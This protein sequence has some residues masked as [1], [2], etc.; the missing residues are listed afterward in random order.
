VP[1]RDY[2]YLVTVSSNVL[3]KNSA[4]AHQTLA[5]R[6]HRL[7]E[8]R[9]E[10]RLAALELAREAAAEAESTAGAAFGE[11]VTETGDPGA[12]EGLSEEDGPVPG[13]EP[14]VNGR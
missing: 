13:D 14:D 7:I 1:G 10:E 5:L 11:A 6:I 9:H 2:H 4:V 8:A 3:R 12:A